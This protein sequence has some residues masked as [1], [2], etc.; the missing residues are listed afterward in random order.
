MDMHDLDIF[1]S[2]EGM[3]AL[4]KQIAVGRTA[5]DLRRTLDTLAQAVES[6]GTLVADFD[7]IER[8]G[9]GYVDDHLVSEG[10]AYRRFRVEY[11]DLVGSWVD[12]LLVEYDALE[13]IVRKTPWETV[14]TLG[15]ESDGSSYVVVF[16]RV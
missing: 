16:E 9:E 13:G 8:R 7:E 14:D 5:A 15:L 3:Y 11:D 1:D 6:G 4:G 10:V 2:F 12:L